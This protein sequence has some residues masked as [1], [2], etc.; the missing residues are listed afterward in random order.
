L[1]WAGAKA[2]ASLVSAERETRSSGGRSGGPA[3]PR[4]EHR[5]QSFF[6]LP[7][8]PPGPGCPQ[9]ARGNWIADMS[10]RRRPKM[11]RSQGCERMDDLAR[12]S[13]VDCADVFSETA[14]RR[15]LCRGHDHDG[16]NGTTSCTESIGV[17]GLRQPR[18]FQGEDAFAAIHAASPPPLSIND[19][20]CFG[21]VGM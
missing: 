21:A 13:A 7:L 5:G 14:K 1:C 9:A 3:H 10:A 6:C 17:A 12:M 2:G 19:K 16:P 15:N 20:S 18:L 11:Q 8:Y 4:G